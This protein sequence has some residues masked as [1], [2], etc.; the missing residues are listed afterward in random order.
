MVGDHGQDVDEPDR[1]A[2]LAINFPELLTHGEQVLW[3]LI[4][5]TNGLWLLSYG[6]ADREKGEKLD[7]QMLRKYWPMLQA[8]AS[9]E[10]PLSTLQDSLREDETPF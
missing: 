7:Y 2:K 5:E 4:R 1:F 3:K 9:G 10:E 8:V 6:N